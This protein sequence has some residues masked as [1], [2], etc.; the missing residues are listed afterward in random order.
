[1]PVTRGDLITQ[2]DVD[3][4]A[5][6]ANSIGAPMPTNF[7]FT[8]F[9]ETLLPPS[10]VTGSI[11]YGAGGYSA[12]G[13]KVLVHVYSYKD[14]GARRHYSKLYA[15]GHV[16]PNASLSNY[17]IEW[18]W[19]APADLVDGYLFV[20]REDGVSGSFYGQWANVTALPFTDDFSSLTEPHTGTLA[21][22]NPV[23]GWGTYAASGTVFPGPWLRELNRIRA[24]CYT[25]FT[26]D[27]DWLVSGP[28]CVAVGSRLRYGSDALVY[29]DVEF[30]YAADDHSGYVEFDTVAEI[31]DTYGP[32]RLAN[33]FGDWTGHVFQADLTFTVPAAHSASGRIVWSTAIPVSVGVTHALSVTSGAVTITSETWT[34]S[35]ST[36]TVD[37]TLSL[38]AGVSNT[39]VDIN[40]NDAANAFLEV[41]DLRQHGLL[42]CDVL[43][44]T[45]TVPPTLAT[46]LHPNS[47]ALKATPSALDDSLGPVTFNSGTYYPSFHVADDTDGVWVARTRPA[48]GV[49]TY[50]DCDL[51]NYFLS[52]YDSSARGPASS[53]SGA[54]TVTPAVRARPALWPVFRDTDFG[55]WLHTSPETGRHPVPYYAVDRFHS[56]V[57]HQTVLDPDEASAVQSVAVSAGYEKLIVRASDATA[58][59][60]LSTS[61]VAVDPDVPGSY[62]VALAGEVRLPDDFAYA[63]GGN[64]HYLVKNNAVA[65]QRIYLRHILCLK[66]TAGDYPGDTPVFFNTLADGQYD[67]EGYSYNLPASTWENSTLI[68]AGR[69]E[70]PHNGYC[71]YQLTVARPPVNN[72]ARIGVI[73]STGEPALTIQVG[74]VRGATF[75]SAGIFVA[76]TTVNLPANTASV[77]VDVFWPVLAGTALAYQCASRVNVMAAVNFQ[78]LVFSHWHPPRS[79]IRDPVHGQWSGAR[80]PN[81]P[82]PGGGSTTSYFTNG[83][84]EQTDHIVLPIAAELYNDIE[85]ILNLL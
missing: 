21:T 34:V 72:P 4:L 69:L 58:T 32:F 73:P 37:F 66:D 25:Y 59:I 10:N 17:T 64:V 2:A 29:G 70:I 84:D 80:Q 16:L 31:G 48:F 24:S 85:A 46:A 3:A 42:S 27:A 49:H 81:P 20:A 77:T 22:R 41:S 79:V 12:R 5:T 18:N 9:D 51:P 61:T 50:L 75:D 62:D 47:T 76:F 63:G 71:I 52:G 7:E 65:A 6:L 74:I 53:V 23:Q 13:E 33:N 60:Y 57:E 15:I 35:G 68:T 54:I 14:F 82:Q 56:C 78:P 36:I 39:R 30:W 40:L 45:E 19:A 55:E 44:A 38:P 28:W 8:Y 11:T 1:M 67:F 26:P 43:L 83:M